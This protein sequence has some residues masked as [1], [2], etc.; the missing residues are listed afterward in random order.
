MANANYPII[1]CSLLKKNLLKSCCTFTLHRGK[2]CLHCS[3]INPDKPWLSLKETLCPVSIYSGRNESSRY[4]SLSFVRDFQIMLL[5]RLVVWQLEH[6][7]P[8]HA[9]YIA[10]KLVSKT[11]FCC[12]PLHWCPGHCVCTDCSCMSLASE[13]FFLQDSLSLVNNSKWSVLVSWPLMG[14]YRSFFV[15]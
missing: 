5:H 7:T 13:S 6:C 1:K 2:P 8:T 10:L 9:C 15:L 3:K 11:G 12:V 14:N 4:H